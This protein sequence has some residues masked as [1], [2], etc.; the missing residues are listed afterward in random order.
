MY[1]YTLHTMQGC[2]L[3]VLAII[4]VLTE[5]AESAILCTVKLLNQLYNGASALSSGNK[6]VDAPPTG[7]MFCHSKLHHRN[8]PP[9]FPAPSKVI[10]RSSVR[11]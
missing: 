6:T 3:C 8:F 1:T 11:G 10:S 9:S 2:C 4:L 7:Q 5:I